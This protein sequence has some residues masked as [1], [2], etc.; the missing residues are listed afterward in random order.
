[1][2]HEG[3]LL[4]YAGR[5]LALLQWATAARH[6]LVLALAAGG[7]SPASVRLR[8][9]LVLLLPVAHRRAGGSRWPSSRRSWRSCASCSSP[10]LLGVGA[11]L[12]LLG[13]ADPPRRGRPMN[14][15]VDLDRRRARS[16][17]AHVRRRSVAVAAV[18]VQALAARGDAAEARRRPTT[19]SPPRRCS[20]RAGLLGGFLLVVVRRTREARPVRA[21]SGPLVRGASA[22]G[23]ALRLALL[24]PSLG[25]GDRECRAGRARARRLRARHGRDAQGNGS[26]DRRAGAGRQR[27]RSRGARE[28]PAAS[29]RSS[30]SASRPT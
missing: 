16:R 26:A 25:L 18:T 17:R 11:G 9:R 2:I 12:A 13:S 27:A 1:M 21:E 6:W 20:A 15:A 29:P 3:P 24:V 30:S 8:C 23:L 19:R 10:R 14:S 22:I 4:E 7:L 5:D 28:R